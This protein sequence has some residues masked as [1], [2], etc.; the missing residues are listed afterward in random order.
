MGYGGKFMYIFRVRHDA[1]VWVDAV[2]P[3][4]HEDRF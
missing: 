3:R 1:L 4:L 2:L